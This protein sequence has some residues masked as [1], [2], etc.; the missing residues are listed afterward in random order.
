MRATSRRWVLDSFQEWFDLF[1]APPS[2]TDWNQSLCRAK[3]MEWKVRRYERTGRPW[4]ASTVVQD[5][6]GSWNAGVIAAGFRPM[7]PRDFALGRHGEALR[8][9]EMA[10]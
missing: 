8:D 1:G 2:A 5:H 9:E 6:F 3:G 10:A 4:P 7:S